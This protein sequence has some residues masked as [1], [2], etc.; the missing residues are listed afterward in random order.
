M[1]WSSAPEPFR[2]SVRVCYQI[3]CILIFIGCKAT[4]EQ[5]APSIFEN[6]SKMGRECTFL[7]TTGKIGLKSA[8]FV[9][10]TLKADEKGVWDSLSLEDIKN[11][12]KMHILLLQIH[13][14]ARTIGTYC[15]VLLNFMANWSFYIEVSWAQWKFTNLVWNRKT[16][17][18]KRCVFSF[19]R[20]SSLIRFG[21][22]TFPVVFYDIRWFEPFYCVL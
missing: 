3:V 19:G 9:R 18:T 22:P 2:V 16:C 1:L 21:Y 14:A 17:R 4:S 12:I 5:P 11:L 6:S 13:L 10:Y 20:K 8:L 7:Q 15:T